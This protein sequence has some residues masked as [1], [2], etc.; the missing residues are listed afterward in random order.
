MDE[1]HQQ[2]PGHAVMRVEKRPHELLVD[3]GYKSE[4]VIPSQELSIRNN[5]NPGDVVT[6]GEAIEQHHANENGQNAL[7]GG[8]HQ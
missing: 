3:I 8:H 4:G 6:V 2:V 1:A 7:P 5:A